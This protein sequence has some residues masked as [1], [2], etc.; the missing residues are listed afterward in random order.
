[1]GF[2]SYSEKDFAKATEHFAK[3][4]LQNMYNKYWLAKAYESAGQK[5]EATTLYKEI[6]NYNFNNMGYA[7]VRSEV[8]KKI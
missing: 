1:M 7:L 5:E 4:N 8:I 6:A 3:T 2:I